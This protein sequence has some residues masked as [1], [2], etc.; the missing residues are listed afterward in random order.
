MEHRRRAGPEGAPWSRESSIQLSKT[1]FGRPNAGTIAAVL[2]Y[3]VAIEVIVQTY[4]SLVRDPFP[5]NWQAASAVTIILGSALT[6]LIYY[7]I[8][9]VRKY[10]LKVQITV[11]VLFVYVDSLI[12]R[13]CAIFYSPWLTGQPPAYGHTTVAS[14]VEATMMQTGAFG[15]W[16]G[17]FLYYFFYE[18]TL[19]GLIDKQAMAEAKLSALRYQIS[20]HFLFN[21]LNSIS[22]LVVSRDNESADQ[23]ILR[24][25]SFFRSTLEVDV[26][27]DIPL[28]RELELQQRYL[29]IEAVR[30]PDEL[31]VRFEV[32]DAALNAMVPSLILQ[33][34]VENSIKYGMKRAGEI[35]NVEIRARRSGPYL[36][37]EVVDDGKG[38]VKSSPGTGVGLRNVRDRLTMRYGEDFSFK[39]APSARGFIVRLELP[40][41]ESA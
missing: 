32:E 3:W 23:M 17:V 13:I 39:A 38:L 31:R 30:F 22:S 5:P 10:S 27:E 8:K 36:E 11:A 20:P 26:S 21:T 14:L 15:T 24:L 35:L 41:T 18:T 33:P 40:W 16:C 28:G 12:L 37:I 1:Q 4:H 34:L 29:D 7:G 19:S 6:F 25:A 2:V 9:S